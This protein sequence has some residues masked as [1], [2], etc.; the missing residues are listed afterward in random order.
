MATRI[1]AIRAHCPRIKL[2]RSATPKQYMRQ[3]TQCTTLSSGVIKNVQES[4]VEALIGMLLEGQ[5]VRT[6]TV[7]YKPCLDL[8]G[9]F[10]VHV[11]VDTRILRAL[12]APGA[13]R[14]TI[15][16]AQNLGLSTHD[17]V[18]QWNFQHPDDEVE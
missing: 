6:G 12:N 3:V 18:A 13:F 2:A 4:E 7:I 14:G 9:N 5:S 15:V 11:K 10:T 16:H 8:K 17:L 1:Q